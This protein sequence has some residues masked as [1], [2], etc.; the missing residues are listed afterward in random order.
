MNSAEHNNVKL[1]VAL[2]GGTDVIAVTL[3]AHTPDGSAK[4]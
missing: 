3:T 1:L 4:P 2:I